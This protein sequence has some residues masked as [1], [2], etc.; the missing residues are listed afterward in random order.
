MSSLAGSPSGLVRPGA[1][2]VAGLLHRLAAPAAGALTVYLAAAPGRWGDP[3]SILLALLAGAAVPAMSR[4]G[5]AAADRAES[6]TANVTAGRCA[7]SALHAALAVPLF[8]VAGA[9][10]GSPRAAFPGSSAAAG[11]LA[12]LAGQGASHVALL[13]AYRGVGTRSRNHE[14]AQFVYPILL[15]SWL[16]PPPV[17]GWAFPA[18]L[19]LG[20]AVGATTLARGLA[21]DLRAVFA[22]RGGVGL[23][24]GTFNP[25]H[26]SHLEMVGRCLRERALERVIIH[27]TVVPKLHAKALECGEIEIA[28]REAGMRVYRT[29]ERAV[30]GVQYF[31]TGNRFY[32]YETRVLMLRLAVDDAGLADRV[33]VWSLPEVY[34]RHGFFGVIAAV[35]SRFP[36][37]PLHG[38]HGSDLGG[39]WNRSI[40]DQAGGI[41]P[42]PV[43][44]G[45][46]VSSTA[47]RAGA[48]EMAPPSVAQ[49]IE[50][51]RCGVD[52]FELRGR[53]FRVVDGRVEEEQ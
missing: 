47:L 33:E 1:L 16:L 30:P 36:G 37:T 3:R 49:L 45:D 24:I 51:L 48:I 14:L 9:L 20:L 6:R 40:F 10:A 44:R 28:T 4:L 42:Y 7:R 41:A 50:A 12:A 52:T 46:G 39:M 8:A 31:P 53:R 23:F 5:L 27:P 11:A 43:R 32:E 2:R 19:A 18:L 25:V 34:A 29:T 17:A 13:L 22:P 21:T 15:A 26:R 35:R 38:I